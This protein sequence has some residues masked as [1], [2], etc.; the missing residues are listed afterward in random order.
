LSKKIAMI[1]EKAKDR[2]EQMEVELQKVK[3]DMT[4]KLAEAE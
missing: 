4:K 2:A 3:E 1:E